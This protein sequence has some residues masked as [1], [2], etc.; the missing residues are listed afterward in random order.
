MKKNIIYAISGII[1]GVILTIVILKQSFP[2]MM[3]QTFESKL[4]Y[5]ETVRMI[6]KNAAENGWAVAKI[7]NMEK[8]MRKAGF[9]DAARVKV[10]ELC[11]ATHTND[12]LSKEDDMFIAAIMPC[13]IA[14]YERKNG[15]VFI[16]KMN[17][18]LMSK[19]FSE[20]VEEVMGQVAE[21]DERILEEIIK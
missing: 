9:E 21:E 10:I 6:E 7:Y 8:R 15:D 18:G 11:H 19:F 17:I 1:V 13:R 3:I 4:D 16:S 2:G 5:P 14:V 12:I 20:N